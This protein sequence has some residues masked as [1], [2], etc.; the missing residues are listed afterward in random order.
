MAKLPVHSQASCPLMLKGGKVEEDLSI[1]ATQDG[2]GCC[3]FAQCSPQIC[4]SPPSQKSLKLPSLSNSCCHW[5]T[6]ARHSFA[7]LTIEFRSFFHSKILHHSFSRS[8]IE[9]RLPP[10]SHWTIPPRCLRFSRSRNHRCFLQ[11]RPTPP[12][13]EGWEWG[14]VPLPRSPCRMAR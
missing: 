11:T 7:R 6:G 8:K 4:E 3:R 2:F 9:P 5:T 13:S 12:I 14:R 1:A 10:L